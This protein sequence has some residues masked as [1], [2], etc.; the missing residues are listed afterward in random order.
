[1][2][3][4]VSPTSNMGIFFG[5]KIGTDTIIHTS[6]SVETGYSDQLTSLLTIKSVKSVI[7]KGT[8]IATLNNSQAKSLFCFLKG[9]YEK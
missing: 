8:S 3:G 5:N 7:N 6:K 1:M 2:Y 9:E 4:T